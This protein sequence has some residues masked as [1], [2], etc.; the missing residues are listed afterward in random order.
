MKKSYP[1][2]G[3]IAWMRQCCAT[4]FDFVLFLLQPEDS[5][6]AAISKGV[7]RRSARFD[8]RLGGAVKILFWVVVTVL[9]WIGLP[10]VLLALA[11]L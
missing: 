9:F 5:G 1:N 10:H 8:N 11:S 2:I 3:L 6:V 7:G 4:V